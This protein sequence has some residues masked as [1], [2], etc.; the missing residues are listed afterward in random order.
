MGEDRPLK[1][2]EALAERYDNLHRPGA[3]YD[4]KNE[5]GLGT[6]PF[7]DQLTTAEIQELNDAMEERLS[8]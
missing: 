3:W 2:F 6:G 7:N 4:L 5:L 8:G 1:R